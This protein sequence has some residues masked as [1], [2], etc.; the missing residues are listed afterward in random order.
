[1]YWAGLK[2]R[3]ITKL[4]WAPICIG[5]ALTVIYVFLNGLVIVITLTY[6]QVSVTLMAMK[7]LTSV[8]K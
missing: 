6:S 1:M 4:P 2:G 7:Q 8:S 5:P 3:E